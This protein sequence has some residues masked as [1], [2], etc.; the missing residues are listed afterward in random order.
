ML[1]TFYIDS[2]SNTKEQLNKR[3][4]TKKKFYEIFKKEIELEIIDMV[5]SN[6]KYNFEETFEHL[7]G[8]AEQTK[9]SHDVNPVNNSDV[10]YQKKVKAQQPLNLLDQFSTSNVSKKMHVV[11]FSPYNQH[12]LYSA[13]KDEDSFKKFVQDTQNFVLIIMRGLPG[14]GKSTKA[15]QLRGANG[16]LYSTDDFFF[17]NERYKYDSTQIS[18]AHEWN[19]KRTKEG[20]KMKIS[21][22][23]IDNTN[24]MAWEMKPY[25]AMAL[26]HDYD[27]FII[28]P[29]TPWAW[30]PSE[31]ADRNAHGVPKEKIEQMKER[32]EKNVTVDSIIKNFN[33]KV[34][35]SYKKKIDPV[36][37]TPSLETDSS[38]VVDKSI[39]M[40]NGNEEYHE[41]IELSC[42]PQNN[43]HINSVDKLEDIG[44]KNVSSPPFNL[45]TITKNSFGKIDDIVTAL[46]SWYFGSDS[47]CIIEDTKR[48]NENENNVVKSTSNESNFSH[49]VKRDKEFFE[50]NIKFLT[51][52]FPLQDKNYLCK[53]FLQFNEN[54]L[55][56]CDY[57]CEQTNISVQ[58]DID[59]NDDASANMNINQNLNFQNCGEIFY[60]DVNND[61]NVN[62]KI[63]QR[64]G[65]ELSKRFG[66]PDD[67]D[68]FNSNDFVMELNSELAQQLYLSWQKSVKKRKSTDQTDLK[69][70]QELRRL[71]GHQTDQTE[72]VDGN[73]KKKRKT[74]PIGFSYIKDTNSDSLHS[75]KNLTKDSSGKQLTLKQMSIREELYKRFPGADKDA[76]NDVLEL[77]GYCLKTTISLVNFSCNLKDGVDN[78]YAKGWK[79]AEFPSHK[80]TIKTEE[81]VKVKNE[82]NVFQNLSEKDQSYN[83]LRAEANQFAELRKIYFK[84][85]AEAFQEKNGPQAQ[86]YAD[87]ACGYTNKMKEAHARAAKIT[88]LRRNAKTS[89]DIIDL[90]GLHVNEGIKALKAHIED[91]KNV[92]INSISVITG[93]GKHSKYNESPL[94]NAVLVYLR[95]C[96][97]RFEQRSQGGEMKVF[98]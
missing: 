43:V 34:P 73:T 59:R 78:I 44:N 58:F 50:F 74:V 69:Y 51:E 94:R 21:P 60:C 89:P 17:I 10:L 25:V 11:P 72:Y 95:K 40:S 31:L 9:K 12:T 85:A 2:D 81:N 84:K 55:T 22:I 1:G 29:D 68:S 16:V 91:C 36:H 19:Q 67:I 92:G 80:L 35:L 45:K 49:E 63:D 54:L 27:I 52:C 79:A 4:E 38:K 13:K 41:Y 30:N 28:E 70:G 82:N 24:M 32:Y 20:M 87:Q 93:W 56:T 66:L 97:Y 61:K 6:C 96:N 90:H 98:I 76:L 86:Y 14:A 23:I 65:M 5:F 42:I 53:C 77:N 26:T 37:S 46:K 39:F 48:K 57:L 71:Q 8:I 83:D 3:N 15:R 64:L 18:D 47:N 75:I 62:I 88:L 7:L 33:L